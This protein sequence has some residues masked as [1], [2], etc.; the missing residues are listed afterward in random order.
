MAKKQYEPRHLRYS[1]VHSCP[2]C[3]KEVRVAIGPLCTIEGLYRTDQ[4]IE[5]QEAEKRARVELRREESE[6]VVFETSLIIPMRTNRK[7]SI[8]LTLLAV[9]HLLISAITCSRF[10]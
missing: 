7:L 5:K 1:E 2:Y 10:L 6:R 3:G 4:T 9:A 8:E